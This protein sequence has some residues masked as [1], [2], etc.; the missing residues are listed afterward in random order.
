MSNKIVELGNEIKVDAGLGVKQILGNIKFEDVSFLYPN[1]PT[2]F[3]L[4]MVT[5][6]IQEGEVVGLAGQYRSGKSTLIKLLLKQEQPTEGRVLIDNINLK[7]LNQYEY[8]KQIIYVAQNPLIFGR[9]FEEY[10]MVQNSAY[11]L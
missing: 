10:F 4:D 5:F 3:V 8:R 6:E 7:E 11:D 1:R 9:T 2:V